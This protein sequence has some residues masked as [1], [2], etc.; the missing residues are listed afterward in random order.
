MK[1]W[2]K[3]EPSVRSGIVLIGF[4]QC[5][6]A[7]SKSLS[8]PSLEPNCT[9]AGI[10]RSYW[11]CLYTVL[12]IIPFLA[13][14]EQRWIVDISSPPTVGGHM[15][16]SLGASVVRC[17]ISEFWLFRMPRFYSS[18]FPDNAWMKTENK[19]GF[20]FVLVKSFCG[21]TWVSLKQLEKLP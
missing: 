15:V 17:R 13:A 20:F 3:P 12:F 6:E 8:Y 2:R 7:I 9:Q 4:A 19:Q 21:S 16:W 18:Y 5:L 11:Y 10:N 1:L 14:L